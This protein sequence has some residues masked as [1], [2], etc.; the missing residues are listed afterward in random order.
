MKSN[1]PNANRIP[2]FLHIPKTAGTTLTHCI[3]DQCRSDEGCKLEEGRLVDGIYYYP[4]GFHKE[5]NIAI[6]AKVIRALEGRDIRA[7]VGHFTFG[8]HTYVKRPWIYMTL[9][10]NPV[11]RVVSLYHACCAYH[12]QGDQD[13]QRYKIVSGGISIEDFVLYSSCRE[14]DND[15][16]RRLSGLEPAFGACSISTLDKAKD[17]LRRYFSIVGVTECFDET[18]IL[19]K[20]TLGWAHE[21]YY[22]PGLVNR[23]KPTRASLPQ[24]SV[25]AILERNELDTKLYEFAKELLYERIADQ[26]PDFNS[27]VR[28]FKSLNTQ[29]IAKHGL[30]N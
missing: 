27:E 1:T 2:L 4:G 11:D 26:G 7:V 28:R 25:D 17:N 8:I 3:Y 24:K 13:T 15:Q 19:I 5:P 9:L 29:Y 14:A 10:R 6:P 22:L 23:D 20:R 18:V 30:P 12:I 21:P 16:T